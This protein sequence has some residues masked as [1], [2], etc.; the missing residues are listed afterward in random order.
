MKTLAARQGGDGAARRIAGGDQRIERERTLELFAIR[1]RC[2]RAEP[3]V[4][5]R[6]LRGA[7]VPRWMRQHDAR[8]DALAALDA[9]DLR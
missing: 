2:E 8:V 4:I 5:E 7:V 1:V 3:R 6:E 9:R